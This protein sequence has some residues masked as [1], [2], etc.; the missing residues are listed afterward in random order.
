L[1][2]R[3]ACEAAADF[4]DGVWLVELAKVSEPA[5]LASVIAESL[6]VQDQSARSQEAV[7]LEYLSDRRLLLVL[8]NCEHLLAA[9]SEL[10]AALLSVAAD[11]TIL[12]TSREPIGI[13]GECSWPVPPLSMP[14]L[15]N[16]APT[17]GGYVYGHE[18]LQ[19]LE[20]RAKA[21]LPD[22]SFDVVS[23]QA[24]TELCRR[25]DG[26]PLAI[27]LAAVRM[28]VL[29]IEQIL[30]RLADRYRLLSSGNRGG[31]AR[32]QTLRA[33]V[34]W[35]YE[36]C[37]AQ[38][39]SLWA[40]LS[41]F[42]DS[43]DLETAEAV[44][45]DDEI[46]AEDIVEVL[47]G[48]V[49][50]SIVL[51][52]GNGDRVRYRLLETIREYGK[53]QLAAWGGDRVFSRKH[54]DHY[55]RLAERFDASWFGPDQVEWG[56]WLEA[57]QAN[58]WVAL[59]HGLTAPGEADAALRMAG[60]LFFFWGACG[61]LKDGRYWLERALDAAPEP[62]LL[63]TRALWVTGFVAMTQGDNGAAM[64]YFDDC[65]ELATELDDKRAPAFAQQF[66]GSAEM[67]KGNLT[68][69][70]VLLTESVASHRDAGETSSLTLLAT[71]QLAFVLCLRGEAQEAIELCDEC[72]AASGRYGEQ[73]A[74]S[75][76]L[77]VSG[78]SRWTRGEFQQAIE[79]LTGALDSK[80]ALR[81]RLGMSAAVELLAWIAMEENNAE[82]AC[83][84][85]G[86]SRRLWASVGIPLFGSAALVAT[87]DLYETKANRKLG[88]KAFQRIRRSGEQ[89]TL[90]N[91]VDFA[92]GRST[93]NAQSWR[94][95]TER[96]RLTK[97]ESEVLRLVAEGLSNREI[98]GQL[99]ISQRTAEG[100]V[101]KILG[102]TG[103]K[104]RSQ[105]V[106]WAAKQRRDDI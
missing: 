47:A 31:P 43:F 103:L 61:H 53:E 24:A 2:K 8:D 91:A 102:K 38:E 92:H 75:W 15:A 83:G 41:V 54:R 44:C 51:R 99:V 65:Y 45:D 55:L 58:L 85:F 33:A 20:E 14:D 76:A 67:F 40:R 62:T 34:D 57:E 6:G 84:L 105:V 49:E 12:A 104:S 74:R 42:A 78:L 71:A 1:A 5:L 98:A 17:R 25:L 37:S 106:A 100:H 27:E 7:L 30:T 101:E 60:A 63:R 36:L 28:R 96:V 11:V 88:A 32:H 16:M 86:A 21:V 46:P 87:H 69:A 48:L 80:Y 64:R 97:R 94:S 72:L 56:R 95:A 18:A 79:P 89:L 73:W 93:D 13:L 26:L 59:D 4:P 50:K 35:S 22:F 19:L 66:R 81:D 10:S 70:Q 39:R 77:W 68:E 3:V 23:K 90:A 29:S 9:C 82:F 52:E